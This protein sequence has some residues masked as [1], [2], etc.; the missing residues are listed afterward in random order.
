MPTAFITHSIFEQHEMLPGHPEN[1]RRL[2]VIHEHL[3]RLGIADFLLHVEAPLAAREQLEQVHSSGHI[4]NISDHAPKH[5]LAFIDGDTSMNPHTLEA[6]WRAAGGAAAATDMVLNGKVHNAFCALR[7]PG[8]HAER[9]QAMG[10]CF[11]N[12]IAVAAAQAL[13]VHGLERVAILDFDVHHGNGTEDIFSPDPRVMVCS[14]YQYPLYPYINRPNQPGHLINT[15]LPSGAGSTEFRSAV[16]QRW[17]PEL[18]TFE[19][20]MVFISAGFDAHRDDPLAGLNLLDGDFEWITEV[21]MQLADKHAGGRIVSCL[22]G[23]YDLGV[24]SRCVPAH[25]KKLAAL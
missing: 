8:H 6:A 19:P 4:D 25:I 17:L 5:G 20:E 7:P 14:S 18:E 24:L 11:F 22:E 23:G 10:F 15:P 12:N 13:E 1:P 9:H 21:A 3:L 16:N 2:Q